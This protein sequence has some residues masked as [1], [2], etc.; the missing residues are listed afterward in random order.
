MKTWYSYGNET[1]ARF[2]ALS[3]PFAPALRELEL[4]VFEDTDLVRVLKAGFSDVVLRT[5]KGRIY[6]GHGKENVA[7]LAGALLLGVGPLV[8]FKLVD[9]QDVE[10]QDEAGRVRHLQ[11]WND[12][13][14]FEVREVWEHLS[15]HYDLHKSVR[16]IW[17]NPKHWHDY[18]EVFESYLPQLQDGITL[19]IDTSWGEFPQIRDGEGDFL[20][21][22]KILQMPGLAKVK[23]C[24]AK[25]SDDFLQT[26][27][28]VL[29]LIE[30]PAG[31][32]VEVCIEVET[33]L[34]VQTTTLQ[35][36][37]LGNSTSWEIC[38]HCVRSLTPNKPKFQSAL[39]CKL[40]FL[41][42]LQESAPFDSGQI[43]KHES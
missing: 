37:L 3:R 26:I 30:P 5:L 29:A 25:D 24:G 14:S 2:E 11:C 33:G 40:I 10:L 12:D 27:S 16:E 34:R 28:D 13:S 23:F 18:V 15:L 4:D 21:A 35:S 22:F 19:A 39:K 32:K 31:R 17:I 36:T 8:D 20:R 42:Y 6:N 38:S 41:L 9:M 7:L 1:E 43:I